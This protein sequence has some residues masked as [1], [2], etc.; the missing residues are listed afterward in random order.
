MQQQK[1]K[2]VPACL[3]GYVALTGST[4]RLEMALAKQ[5]VQPKKTGDT[6]V[7][8]ARAGLPRLNLRHD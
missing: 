8:Q 7:A 1:N 3:H 2:A 5:A 6:R 4:W